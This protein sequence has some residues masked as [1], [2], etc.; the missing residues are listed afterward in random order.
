[1]SAH[2]KNVQ[3]LNV[4]LISHQHEAKI[5]STRFHSVYTA[6]ITQTVYF[7]LSLHVTVHRMGIS[8]RGPEE[9]VIQAL[10]FSPST[11][12]P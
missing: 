4:N 2:E 12:G 1:M 3:E 6:Y 11:V 5:N 7:T 10:W 8:E 9:S